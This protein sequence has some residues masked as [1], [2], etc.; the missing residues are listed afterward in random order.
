MEKNCFTCEFNLGVCA[1]GATLIDGKSSYG[2]S[3]EE[4]IKLFPNGCDEWGI[5]LDAFIE[6]QKK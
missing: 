2:M 6:Q 1:G 4:M 3:I 5:S